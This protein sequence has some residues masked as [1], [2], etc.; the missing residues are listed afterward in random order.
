MKKIES[1]LSILSGFF[2]AIVFLV[3][4]A[5]VVQRYVLHIPIPWANDIIRISFIYSVFLGMA[6]GVFKKAHINVDVLVN[7]LPSRI[8]GWSAIFTNIILLVFL[9]VVLYFSY[10][11]TL[12]NKDQFTTYLFIPM[13]YVYAIV[14]ISVF[15]MI[16]FLILD[17][18]RIF[19]S[20]LEFNVNT[21]NNNF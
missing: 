20:V 8:K 7:A 19:M 5:Q 1:F 13:S 11:F 15:L 21:K 10:S 17:T 2:I 12:A 16:V 4:F 6:V 14:P 9:C 3:T 18:V